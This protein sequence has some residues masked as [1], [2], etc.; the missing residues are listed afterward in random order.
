VCI[1]AVSPKDDPHPDK[2]EGHRIRLQKVV[3]HHSGDIKS[4]GPF[5]G[6][7]PV[8]K[9]LHILF[10]NVPQG[11]SLHDIRDDLQHSAAVPSRVFFL[12]P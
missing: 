2:I 7:R 1:S 6:K 8:I 3:S 11:T 12:T 5:P 9:A 4:P 10:A